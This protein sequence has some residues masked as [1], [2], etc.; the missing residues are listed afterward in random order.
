MLRQLPQNDDANLLVGFNTSD[1]AGVYQIDSET[2]LITTADFITPTSDDPYLFGQISAA[3]SMSDVWAMGGR[4]LTCINL[5][6]LPSGK[7]GPEI[8]RGIIEGALS[9]ITEAG[10]VLAGG[11][12]VDDAE[13]KFGLAVTGIVHPQK[14]WRNVGAQPG[15][16]LILTKPLGSGAIFNANLKNWV[17]EQDL[18]TCFEILTTLNRTACEILQPF[19]IHAA[20]DITGFGLMGHAFEMASGS[21]VTFDLHFEALPFLPSALH[22][23][24]KGINTG[25]N[26]NN[27]ALV[28]D[29]LRWMTERPFFAQQMLADPMTNGGLLIALPAKQAKDSL[30]KLHDAGVTFANIIGEVQP[31]D[32]TVALRIF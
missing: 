24:E 23:Y 11:H 32:E 28:G 3:N 4:P 26:A 30:Q 13:P 12:T 15:D 16:A 8:T 31:A 10:A 9:K 18:A 2:A 25:S 17:P 22:M 6:A 21:G 29:R 1:D 20:T 14:I 27:F 7:L 19:D 5:L